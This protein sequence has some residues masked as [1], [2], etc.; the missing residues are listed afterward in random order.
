MKQ[1][2]SQ[3]CLAWATR[4]AA[5]RPSDLSPAEN[6]DLQAHLQTCPSCSSVYTAYAWMD[7]AIRQLPPV[8]P[9]QLLSPEHFE[10]KSVENREYLTNKLTQLN[11]RAAHHRPRLSRMGRLANLLAAVLVVCVLIAG[12]LILFT[13]HTGTTRVGGEAGTTEAPD[14]APQPIPAGLCENADPGLKNLCAHHQLTK[15]DRSKLVDGIPVTL[16]YAYADSNRI[17]ILAFAQPSK[18]FSPT[19]M[20]IWD[21]LITT[22]DGHTFGGLGGGGSNTFFYVN[23]DAATV[24]ASTH[25][26][27]LRL[28]ASVFDS[29]RSHSALAS[30][31]F[32]FTVPFHLARIATPV[33]TITIGGK[34]VTLDRVVIAP[35]SARVYLHGGPNVPGSPTQ[36]QVGKTTINGNQVDGLWQP[37]TQYTSDALFEYDVSLYDQK[38]PWTFT[39]TPPGAGT[40]VFHFSEPSQPR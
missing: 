40:Y 7:T 14:L 8:A 15:I 3:P 17:A 5:R 33:Q 29:S 36:L 16:A 9:L 13:H 24:P 1:A 11:I 32:T 18:P 22:S 34:S 23:Y 20:L 28:K 26:L 38:G 4:L 19:E 39:I 2:S 31:T 27:Q 25:L 12:S 6:T 10:E 37:S 30:A 35:S 21:G